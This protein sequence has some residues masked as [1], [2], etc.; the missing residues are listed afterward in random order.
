MQIFDIITKKK[1]GAALDETEINFAVNGY[2]TGRIGD[3]PM[4]ALL[5]AICLKGLNS[6]EIS[7]L[8]RC[9]ANSG[10]IADFGGINRPVVDKHSTGGVGDKLTL[11]VGPM[12]AATG[13]AVAKMSGG[14]LGHTGGTIDKLATIPGFETNL[15]T[16]DFM[17]ILNNIGICIASQTTSLA[18]ADKKIYALRDATATVDSI[19]LIA[20]SVMSKKI[21]A[22]AGAILLDVKAGSGAFMKSP[23]EAANLAEIMVK[24][25]QNCG[26]KMAAV[27]SAMDGPLGRCVGNASEVYEAAEVLC[28]R[29]E[30]D[31]EGLAVILTAHMLVLADKGNFDKCSQMA[32]DSIKSGKAFC[33]FLE[34]VEAQ[35]GKKDYFTGSAQKAF[36]SRPCRVVPSPAT[37]YIKSLNGEACGFA[38][39]LAG[40]I[41][42]HAKA[43]DFVEKGGILAEF[44]GENQAEWPPNQAEATLLSAY[45]FSNVPPPPQTLIYRLIS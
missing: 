41:V 2:T 12:A 7:T 17:R 9:M 5:M 30:A 16:T 13:V 23:E 45:E 25:G 32:K 38:A 34:M 28:G 26:K 24:I 35:G 18:P 44:Y 27:V 14:A 3:G 40:D 4:A 39:K 19:P 20:A 33:K 29:G 42:F 37:G 21:A 31:L 36:L 22:G 11:I 43:G 6:D 8:T 15:T 1:Q 10:E